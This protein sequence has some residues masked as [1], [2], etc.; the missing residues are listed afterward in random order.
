ANGREYTLQAGDAGYSI[1]AVVTP[2]GSSQPALAGAVQ[3]SPS[4]DAYGAPSVTN[5]HISGTPKV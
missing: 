1:K 2:T 5:L 4:V 3:S